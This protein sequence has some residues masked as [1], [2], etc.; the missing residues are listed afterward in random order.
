MS[1]TFAVFLCLAILLGTGIQGVVISGKGRCKCLSQGSSFVPINL[2]KKVE[3]HPVTSSCDHVEII[4]TLK[5]SGEEQCLNPG[6]KMVRQI[7]KMIQ[8]K[9]SKRS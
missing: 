1:R 6:S 4:A 7:L 9:G 3:M 5:P 8:T 2:L